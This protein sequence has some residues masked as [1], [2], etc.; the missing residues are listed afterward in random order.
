MFIQDATP[1][2]FAYMIAGYT[3]FFVLIILYLFS[4]FIRTRNLNKD[5]TILESIKEQNQPPTGRPVGKK[6]AAGTR[7][8]VKQKTTGPKMSKK[9]QVKKKVTKKK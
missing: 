4:L 6:A 3:I 5:L 9:N 2:T 8:A 1:D 7:L